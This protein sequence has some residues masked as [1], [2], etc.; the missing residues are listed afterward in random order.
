M[1]NK[2]GKTLNSYNQEEPTAAEEYI[3]K[4]IKEYNEQKRNAAPPTTTP[5]NTSTTTGTNNF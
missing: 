1:K 2:V 5:K 4:A 3:E